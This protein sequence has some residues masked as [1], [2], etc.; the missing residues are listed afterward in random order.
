MGRKTER[1]NRRKEITHA[2]AKV[3]ANHGYAGA[4]VEAIA[5]EAGL[6]PGLLH[7]HFKN[8]KEILE[9][10][11]IDL[12]SKF[13]RRAQTSKGLGNNGLNGYV[14]SALKL[15]QNSDILAAKCWVGIFAEALRDPDLFSQ[16]KKHLDHEVQYVHATSKG[17]LSLQSSGAI[18][19]F[20]LGSLLFGAFAPKRTIGFAAPSAKLLLK[21][22]EKFNLE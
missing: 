16:L 10:L 17:S 19:A 1:Q 6:S 12:I 11:V 8:K 14:D 22:L 15:D 5:F 4:T 7:H 13:Q 9:E 2:F 20:I 18:I 21:A 3:L